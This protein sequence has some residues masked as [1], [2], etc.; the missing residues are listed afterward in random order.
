M[1]M[2]FIIYYL[3][4]MPLFPMSAVYPREL[5]VDRIDMLCISLTR[6]GKFTHWGDCE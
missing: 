1:Y 4:P 3:F 6:I 2:P 5:V